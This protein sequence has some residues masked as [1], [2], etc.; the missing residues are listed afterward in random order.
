MYLYGNILI[1]RLE[2]EN[3]QFIIDKII[4][5]DGEKIFNQIY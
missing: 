2:G 3:C 4:R 5:R 1:V